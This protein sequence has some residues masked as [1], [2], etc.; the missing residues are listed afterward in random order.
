MNLPDPPIFHTR[1]GPHR[2]RHQHPIR[3]R[4]GNVSV[5]GSC[6]H[7]VACSKCEPPTYAMGVQNGVLDLIT[8]YA[9][10]KRQFDKMLASDEDTPVIVLLVHAGYAELDEAA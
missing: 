4:N 7:F 8:W 9:V 10:D 5:R 6:L 3:P 2:C 1:C